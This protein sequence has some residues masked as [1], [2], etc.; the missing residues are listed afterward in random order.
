MNKIQSLDLDMTNST[1]ISD[2]LFCS[3]GSSVNVA[4]TVVI[5]LILLLLIGIAILVYI[6]RRTIQD[7]LR[8]PKFAR[9]ST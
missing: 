2:Q 3:Q 4:A 1:I 9:R 6:K 8:L 7:R 5:P